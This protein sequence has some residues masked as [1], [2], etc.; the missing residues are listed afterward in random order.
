MEHG[1]KNIAFYVQKHIAALIVLSK[2]PAGSWQDRLG[3]P[4]SVRLVYSNLIQIL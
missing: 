1:L 4:T 2:L 3:A